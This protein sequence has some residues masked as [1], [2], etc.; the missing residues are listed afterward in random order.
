MD[1]WEHLFKLD[2]AKQLTNEQLKELCHSG[3]DGIIIGGT[4]D[5]TLDNVVDLFARVTE[6][7]IP[8]GLEVSSKDAI[9]PGFVFYLI[10]IDFYS[11]YYYW[12]LDIQLESLLLY[13]K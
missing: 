3:T 10:P 11:I 7:D 1:E 13:I 8:C 9:A 5:V 6:Y 2:P 4:D 12:I